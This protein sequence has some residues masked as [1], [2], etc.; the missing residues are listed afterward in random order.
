M[1]IP[2]QANV[3]YNAVEPNKPGVPGSLSSNT[4]NTEVFTASIP[5]YC[6]QFR[7]GREDCRYGRLG[8][9]G[10]K[11]NKLVFAFF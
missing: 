10:R 7:H 8:A 5:S 11:S 2:N 6:L 1:L 3:T 4:V 9:G